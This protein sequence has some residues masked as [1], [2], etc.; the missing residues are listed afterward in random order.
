MKTIQ[1]IAEKYYGITNF[2]KSQ[3]RIINRTLSKKN[4]LVIMPTG[5]GKSLCFQIPALLFENLTIVISPLISLMKDQVDALQK[6]NIDA[7][8]IN[9]SLQ[10][11]DREM[12]YKRIKEGAY[13]LLYITP[14][15]FR[16]ADFCELISKRKVDL[17]AIDE[18]HCISEWGHDFRPDYTRMNE[19]I[20]LLNKPTVIALTA[21]ATEH[22]EKDII[23]QT[24]LAEADFEIFHEGIDRPNLKLDVIELFGETEKR[25][26]I[27][28]ILEA[29]KNESGIIYFSLIKN[30]KYMSD[31]LLSKKIKHSLYHG[32][33]DKNKRRQIQDQ[34]MHKSGQLVLATNAFGMGIDKEDIRF[35]I[36]SELPGSIESYYQ[37]IGRAGRDGKKS[38]CVLLYD[39]SDLEIQLEFL[40]WQNPS[41]D[42][43][44]RSYDFIISH[45]EEVNAYGIDYLKENLSFKNRRDFRVLTV[46]S[47]FDR[48]HIS[49]GDIELKNFKIVSEMNEE[50]FNEDNLNEKLK[51]DQSKL[52]A[53]VQFTKVEENYFDYLNHYFGIK[54]KD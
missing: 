38:Q 7:T 1:E 40:N 3:E 5:M 34:F 12:R 9:S 29:N 18:A 44:M 54:E 14:E 17:L 43:Y 47:M 32:D 20:T 26:E 2:R 21:T 36:H 13:K 30:L 49:T 31:V 15:R 19:I 50:Y 52:L 33:L 28:N 25:D 46:L 23:K 10:K 16:K 35:I 45:E 6:K 22:V 39:E 24:G 37:E 41:L 53:M 11:K 42:F 8:F 48:H 27:L 51:R 4:S